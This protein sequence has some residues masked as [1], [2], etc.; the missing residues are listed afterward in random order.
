[1]V[2]MTKLDKIPFLYLRVFSKLREMDQLLSASRTGRSGGLMSSGYPWPVKSGSQQMPRLLSSDRQCWKHSVCFSEGLWRQPHCPQQH[3][4]Y[5][6][7]Y[8]PIL[9]PRSLSPPL[10]PA[11]L[12]SFSSKYCS[13]VLAS[14]FASRRVQMENPSFY[15]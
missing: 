3:L 11:S 12:D 1:M 15:L 5:T 10:S 2:D 9:L 4:V 14:G 13:Q 8:W 6:P 7:L